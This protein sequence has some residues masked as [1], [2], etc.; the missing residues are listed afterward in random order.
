MNKKEKILKIFR[1]KLEKARE[2]KP[3]SDDQIYYYGGL[4]QSFKFCIEVIEKELDDEKG[5][6][7]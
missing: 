3:L 6:N 7:N 1:E 2:A 5:S 4:V